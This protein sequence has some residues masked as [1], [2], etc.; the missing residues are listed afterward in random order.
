MKF[1]ETHIDVEAILP[2]CMKTLGKTRK[3]KTI[4][5]E[6]T[7]KCIWCKKPFTL[8]RRKHE[9]PIWRHNET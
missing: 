3:E 6:I 8:E 5:F 4:T 9:P 1:K 7:I 2:C